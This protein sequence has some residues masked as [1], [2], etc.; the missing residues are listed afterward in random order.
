[1]ESTKSNVNLLLCVP[2]TIVGQTAFTSI[3][4][5]TAYINGALRTAGF[6]VFCFCPSG[7]TGNIEAK[8][9]QE[10]IDKKIDIVLCGGLTVQ[11]RAIKTIFETAKEVSSSI[12]TI[13]GGGGFTSEPLL[14]SEMTGADYAVIGEGDISTVELIHC[15]I[16]RG[17]F[18]EIRGIVYK[19]SDGEYKETL[20]REPIWDLDSIPFPSYE[21][22]P[23][24]KEMSY[25]TPLSGF[26][27]FYADEPRLMQ[28]IYS[29]SCPF[30]CSFC[31]HPTGDKFRSRSMD[32]FFRELDRYVEKYDING[33]V[34]VDEY[35]RMDD[36]VYEFCRRMKPYNLRWVVSLV[37]KTVTLEKLI[38]MKE[39]GCCSVSYGIESMSETVLRDMNK[40][41]NP[42][43]IERALELTIKAGISVQGNL[44]FGAEAET[45]D[46][47]KETLGWWLRNRKYQLA[48]NIVTPYPGSLYYQHCVERGI[49]RSRR[50]YIELACPWVNMSHLSDFEFERLITLISLPPNAK[51]A[52]D[53]ACHSEI[54]EIL[55]NYKGNPDRVSM[56][57]KCYHCGAIHT[58]GNLPISQVQGAFYMP[59][60]ACG[61]LST[62][63]VYPNMNYAVI[64]QWSKNEINNVKLSDWLEK[65]NIKRL[66][67]YGLGDLGV[68]IYKYVEKLDVE[69]YVTDK[70]ESA[71]APAYTY[72]KQATYVDVDDLSALNLDLVLIAPSYG[73]TEIQSFLKGQGYTGQS[74]TL[75]DIVFGV[76][77]INE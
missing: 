11:Y 19:D 67:I 47:A 28:I 24:E 75:F 65:R 18:S 70:S 37:A 53:F 34:I 5:G 14:F 20:Y 9:K 69:I 62:Y 55:P 38:A 73:K 33:I 42:E 32:S 50:E 35:F 21:D 63:G 74:E 31:F 46:T 77:E 1:M 4:S 25:A 22:L 44:I 54:I 76:A 45:P 15:I 8:L 71:K 68:V 72:M 30:K 40:P 16:S 57:L 41:A 66:A 10:I 64:C 26:N 51:I 17:D 56:K 7:E 12:I 43:I 48:L 23:I 13:G 59:C 39:A 52:W 27:T 3:T 36:S 58:Y 29:R 61:M 6:N 2:Y 60:R 49:I